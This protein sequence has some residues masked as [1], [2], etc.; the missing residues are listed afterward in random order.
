[1]AVIEK[2]RTCIITKGNDAGKKVTVKEIIDSNF[3]TISGEHV[4][5]R[6]SNIKHLEPISELA[7]A[8]KVKTVKTKEKKARLKKTKVKKTKKEKPVKKTAT[9]KA[10]K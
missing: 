10:E 7:K 6:R 9:K 2:G 4:K 8:V 3:V 5:E 1:M